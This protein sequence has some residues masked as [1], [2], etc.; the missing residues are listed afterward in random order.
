MFW[1]VFGHFFGQLIVHVLFNAGSCV[2]GFAIFF[3]NDLGFDWALGWERLHDGFRL[4]LHE[5]F[6]K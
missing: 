2:A 6:C 1:P 3:A 4:K 5:S